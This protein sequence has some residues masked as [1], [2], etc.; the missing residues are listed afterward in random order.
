[1]GKLCKIGKIGKRGKK[2][3]CFVKEEGFYRYNEIY[4]AVK[5]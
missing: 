1:M 4:G 3:S 5:Y 2:H